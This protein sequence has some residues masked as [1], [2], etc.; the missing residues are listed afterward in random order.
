MPR[1]TNKETYIHKT[2]KSMQTFPIAINRSNLMTKD[3]E[4]TYIHKTTNMFPVTI[5]MIVLK[6]LIKKNYLLGLVGLLISTVKV[7]Y[8]VQES[9]H[10]QIQKEK[11]SYSAFQKSFLRTV[12]VKH[13]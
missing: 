12:T 5:N 6:C 11:L 2:A 9:Q 4:G 3:T 1:D 10:T 13:Y 8:V 7:Y